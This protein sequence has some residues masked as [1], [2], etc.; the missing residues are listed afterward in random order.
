ML[1]NQEVVF[2]ES[3]FFCEEETQASGDYWSIYNLAP[4]IWINSDGF[5]L[6]WPL[7]SAIGNYRIQNI[8]SDGL[9]ETFTSVSLSDEID[10]DKLLTCYFDAQSKTLELPV[11]EE[12]WIEIDNT[13]GYIEIDPGDNNAPGQQNEYQFFYGNVYIMDQYEEAAA[14]YRQ[15]YSSLK[16]QLF[17]KS[18][19]W[20]NSTNDSKAVFLKV[21]YNPTTTRYF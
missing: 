7:L 12:L 10:H 4:Q 16:D 2:S 8:S 20:N 6:A 11:S 18:I 21:V 3:Y 1:K 19:S 13:G 17:V 5:T 15:R 14:I 9:S